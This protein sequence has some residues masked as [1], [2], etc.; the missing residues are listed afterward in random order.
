[1]PRV[2]IS[3]ATLASSEGPHLQV[4]RD[5]GFEIV[6]PPTPKLLTEQELAGLLPGIH[7]TLAGPETYTPEVIRQAKELRVIARSGVGYDAVD[8]QAATECGVAV[9]ITPG[10]NHESVAEQTFALILALAK[11]IVP[12]HQEVKAGGW[13]RLPSLALRGSTLGIVGLGRIGKAVALRGECFGMKLLAAEAYPDHAF[14]RQHGIGL[15]PL[16]ELLRQSDYVTL[17]APLIPETKHLINRET[18]ALMK[19]GAFLVN[20]ARGGLVNEAD[21]LAALRSN[22]IAGAGLDVFEVEPPGSSPLFALDNVVLSPHIAGIDEQ[23]WR[24]MAMM[25]AQTIAC[26]SRG[27]WPAEQ[28]VNPEV[29][30]RFRW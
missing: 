14:I 4:L 28:I 1:M 30:S 29:R 13:K 20:T 2:L 17:H 24:D 16:A 8:V 21:L 27:D 25:A 5:A 6:F 19:P 11:R 3:S 18:L 26:L 7:A 15:V 9:A 23:S 10:T 22:R 12:R